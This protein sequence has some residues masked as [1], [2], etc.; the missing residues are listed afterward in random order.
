VNSGVNSVAA[1]RRLA[2]QL[3]A[4]QLGATLF[5]TGIACVFGWRYG[6]AV[7][8][9]GLAAAAG[10]AV[11]GLRV[12]GPSLAPAGVVLARIFIG[13]ALKWGVIA[14]ALYLAMV[15]AELP[16][17]AVIVGLMA[18]LVPQLLGLH[19]GGASRH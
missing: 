15:Q 18:A 13:S 7:L 3:V 10:S 12:F 9:G 1:G 16:G 2:T 8:C 11:L 5:S 6:L 14:L 17:L 4:W 19:Q